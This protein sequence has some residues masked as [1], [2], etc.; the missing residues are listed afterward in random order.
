MFLLVLR[1]LSIVL[2]NGRFRGHPGAPELVFEEV[3]HLWEGQHHLLVYGPVGVL[4][5]HGVEEG[6]DQLDAVF[7]VVIDGADPVITVH[8]P[9]HK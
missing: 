1:L 3:N 4:L 6:F 7:Q 5:Q 9:L 2:R 8:Y